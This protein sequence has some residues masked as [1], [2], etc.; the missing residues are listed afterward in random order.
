MFRYPQHLESAVNNRKKLKKAEQICCY[1]DNSRFFD[2][3]AATTKRLNHLAVH[4]RK[5]CPHVQVT[6]PKGHEVLLISP[7]KY[8]SLNA[9][10]PTM[11]K[12][13]F[14]K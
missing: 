14:G 8:E 7:G 5:G 13:T 4:I 11:Q 9:R 10:R 2:V 1:C 3:T 6:C 12:Y